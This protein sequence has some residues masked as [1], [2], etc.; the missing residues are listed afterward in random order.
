MA[1]QNVSN[2][3]LIMTKIC[4]NYSRSSVKLAIEIKCTGML[5]GIFP[6]GKIFCSHD[7][8]FKRDWKAK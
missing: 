8:G 5:S 2:Y 3:K 7:V 4:Q 6:S 1:I